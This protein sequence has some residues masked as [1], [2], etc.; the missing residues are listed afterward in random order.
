MDASAHN[1]FPLFFP[2]GSQV[3][4]EPAKLEKLTLY[5]RRLFLV[6]AN[7]QREDSS[8]AKTALEPGLPATQKIK[9]IGNSQPRRGTSVDMVLQHVFPG[10]DI[11]VEAKL[12]ETGRNRIEIISRYRGRTDHHDEFH[13]PRI[14]FGE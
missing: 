4:C 13:R 8:S 11:T 3:E 12:S 6:L 9:R 14:A 2:T 7:Q 1:D 10:E 5:R